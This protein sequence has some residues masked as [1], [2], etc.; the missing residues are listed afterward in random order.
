MLL[1]SGS[2]TYMA[3]HI[4]ESTDLKNYT[5]VLRWCLLILIFWIALISH[6]ISCLTAT[7]PFE[8]LA[9]K[10]CQDERFPATC[11]TASEIRGL[12]TKDASTIGDGQQQCTGNL[13]LCTRCTCV[14]CL[15][16]S[17]WM[18]QLWFS[19]LPTVHLSFACSPLRFCPIPWWSKTKISEA[20]FLETKL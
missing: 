2:G 12:I 1:D 9:V 5:T 3:I 10:T 16:Y 6:K 7:V 11:W 19:V 17:W 4:A 14:G 8:Q 20:P 13:T 18:I 15:V